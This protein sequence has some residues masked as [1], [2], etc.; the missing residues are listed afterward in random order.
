MSRLRAVGRVKSHIIDLEKV[1][2]SPY[3]ARLFC[4][5][6][7]DEFIEHI[8]KR[9]D[10]NKNAPLLRPVED[11]F[12]I[13]NGHKRVWAAHVAGL[14]RV[15][16]RCIYSSDEQAARTFVNAHLSSYGP[17]EREKATQTILERFETETAREI[18]S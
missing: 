1:H 4:A 15:T 6:D 11:G 17:L 2:P 9:G 3:H 5:A 14:S 16:A 13:L 8:R 12:E 7:N 18:V 10:L